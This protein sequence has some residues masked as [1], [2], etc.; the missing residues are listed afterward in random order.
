MDHV[1]K[2][3][4]YKYVHQSHSPINP[5]YVYFRD[6]FL[7][8]FVVREG[9]LLTR[10]RYSV[11]NCVYK[12]E[13]T[14]SHP[15]SCRQTL[16]CGPCRRRVTCIEQCP[17]WPCPRHCGS[18]QH[19]PRESDVFFADLYIKQKQTCGMPVSG[20]TMNMCRS[21]TPGAM[22]PDWIDSTWMASLVLPLFALS[23]PVGGRCLGL[24]VHSI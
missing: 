24:Q 1:N 4:R 10:S 19:T 2:H 3:G 17:P 6:S 16:M 23:P 13:A 14:I 12:K 9:W 11:I 8:A 20:L 18:V 22:L 5:R 15:R 21:A 7:P